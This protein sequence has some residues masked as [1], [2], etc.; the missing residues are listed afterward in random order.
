MNEDKKIK[1][2]FRLY[3]AIQLCSLRQ[4]G[5][6]I[7]YCSEIPSDIINYLTKQLDLPPTL[8]VN[9]PSRRKT[10]STQRQGLLSYLQFD[11][12]E[13]LIIASFESWIE[14]EARQG[15]LPNELNF[16]AQSSLLKNKI[17]LPGKSVLDRTIVSICNKV[18]S[19]M[20]ENIYKSVP[21]DLKEQIDEA[22]DSSN[23]SK[24]YFSQLKQYPPY[25]TASSINLYLQLY[26]KLSSFNLGACYIFG[27]K[28]RLLSKLC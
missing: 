4:T 10:I 7:K 16:E 24:S 19:E 25:S 14:A 23:D 2:Y 9:E 26:E 28:I 8:I 1:S 12:Y 13:G 6:Y 18:H 27:T 22:L 21:I 17:V 20:F 3:F 11:R 15:K 5:K